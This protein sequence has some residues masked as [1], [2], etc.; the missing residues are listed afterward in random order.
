MLEK[1]RPKLLDDART[2]FGFLPGA[3]RSEGS[4]RRRCWDSDGFR[5]WPEMAERVR[6]VRSLE[7]RTVRRQRDDQW[8]TRT[9]D[10]FWVTTLPTLYASTAAVVSMGHDRWSVENQAFNELVNR[11]HADHVYKHGPTAI[12]AFY[13]RNLKPAAR[14][15]SYTHLTL[16]TIYSV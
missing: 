16:P 14:P 4:V 7:T 9:P 6:V 13:C 3:D 10:W 8:E 12:L 1:N 15:V 5:S 11:W 2:L